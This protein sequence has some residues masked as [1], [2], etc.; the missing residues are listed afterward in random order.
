MGFAAEL[1]MD[2]EEDANWSVAGDTF[3]FIFSRACVSSSEK[4][5]ILKPKSPSPPPHP[6]K[7]PSPNLMLA[8]DGAKIV[9]GAALQGWD[10]EV[11]SE[12]VRSTVEGASNLGD[13]SR[14]TVWA[15]DLSQR[16]P[17]KSEEDTNEG[18]VKVRLRHSLVQGLKQGSLECFLA[19]A[20]ES[21]SQNPLEGSPTDVDTEEVRLI[22]RD[23]IVQGLVD[24]R[25]DALLAEGAANSEPRLVEQPFVPQPPSAPPTGVVQSPA[26][27]RR[28]SSGSNAKH[29]MQ[30]ISDAD[31]KVGS[32]QVQVADKERQIKDRDEA[33][34][35]LTGN[36]MFARSDLEHL[37]LD[38][39]WHQEQI[40]VAEDRFS[41]LNDDRRALSLKL[42]EM[43]L[44]EL[45]NE[46]PHSA[47]DSTALSLTSTVTG[48]V[49]TAVESTCSWWTTGR[50][51]TSTQAVT[52]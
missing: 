26:R 51:V 12:D 19:N 10:D 45:K 9:M 5:D 38:V 8:Q 24:G 25:L 1:I 7:S 31:R 27:T 36:I 52:E 3:N 43:R 49:P 22:A 17:F 44:K 50:S 18:D 48:G 2:V 41:Q 16:N 29:V 40:Q 28:L 30:M 39:Q 14:S 32:L 15:D 47:K 4:Q 42:D 33:C 34:E 20:H 46:W 6:S 37:S 13:D 21:D 11:D 23:K 35:K